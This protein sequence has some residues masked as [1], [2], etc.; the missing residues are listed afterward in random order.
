M[1]INDLGEGWR[2]Q[3]KKNSEALLHFFLESPSPAKN[4]FEGHSPGKKDFQT[5]LL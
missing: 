5:G 4:V 3:E 2:K 1:T